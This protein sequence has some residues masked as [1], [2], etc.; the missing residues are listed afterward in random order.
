M[1]TIRLVNSYDEEQV[2][3]GVATDGNVRV[4]EVEAV[5]RTTTTMLVLPGDVVSRLGLVQQGYR[6][7]RYPDG[8]IAALPWVGGIRI[9]VLGRDAAVNALVDAAGTTPVLGH[10]P[11]T[12][13]DLHVDPVSGELCPDPASPNEPVTDALT[14][15]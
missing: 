6:K 8:R 4:V 3:R 7:V 11:L 12:A 9:T 14:A 5:V 2:R 13:L 15:A 1:Q 10:I